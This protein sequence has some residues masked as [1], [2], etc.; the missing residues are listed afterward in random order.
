MNRGNAQLFINEL[1][2]VGHGEFR[3]GER[4]VSQM[5]D[6]VAIR[7]TDRVSMMTICDHDG[8]ARNDAF[9]GLETRPLGDSL[10]GVCNT[11][12]IG[13]RADGLARIVQ[14]F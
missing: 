13:E 11:Q 7:P 14:G 4:A 12:G 10:D 5:P 9:D 1:V 2:H 3:A 8:C 6:F